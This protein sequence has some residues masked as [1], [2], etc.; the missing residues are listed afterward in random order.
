MSECGCG[1]TVHRI[2]GTLREASR[3]A[4]VDMA[5]GETR[6]YMAELLTKLQDHIS[7]A[8][9][10]CKADLRLVRVSVENMSVAVE[11]GSRRDF[12]F[13]GMR[14]RDNLEGAL[15]RCAR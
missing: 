15:E 7:E 6:E 9:L 13:W 14:A 10:N 12:V 3:S 8:E 1:L 2:L 11:A 5:K 4:F